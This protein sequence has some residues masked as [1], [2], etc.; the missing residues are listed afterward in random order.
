MN[1]ILSNVNLYGENMNLIEESY[2][3][4]LEIGEDSGNT[5]FGVGIFKAA[6]NLGVYYETIGN[7]SKAKQYYMLSSKYDYKLVIDRLKFLE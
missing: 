6:Y 5:V 7:I 1:L 4:C 3:R 2:L